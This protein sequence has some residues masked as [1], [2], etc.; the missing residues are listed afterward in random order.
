MLV[1]LTAQGKRTERQEAAGAL[2]RSPML[3]R[4]RVAEDP[5]ALEGQARERAVLK[6]SKG[7]HTQEFAKQFQ[8]LVRLKDLRMPLK[9][10]REKKFSD[11]VHALRHSASTPVP[12]QVVCSEILRAWA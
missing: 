10:A 1:S 2:F 11:V 4:Q 12:L 6:I 9:E 7:I 8:A 5:P 3:K